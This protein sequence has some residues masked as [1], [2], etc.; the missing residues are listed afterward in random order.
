MTA[1]HSGLL[2]DISL[3]AC[4]FELRFSGLGLFLRNG[5]LDWL[6]SRIDEIF[7]LFKTEARQLA[8]GFDA[9][10]FV[11][12]D[13]GQNDVNLGLLFGRSCLSTAGGARR[14]TSN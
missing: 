14:R 2:L 11:R 12:A 8:D 9:L 6:R 10:D 7:G 4:L 5:F 3:C 13:F 1:L